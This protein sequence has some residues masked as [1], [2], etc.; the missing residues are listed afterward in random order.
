MGLPLAGIFQNA[1]RV[2]NSF[3]AASRFSMKKQSAMRFDLGQPTWNTG[4]GR[5][6][7]FWVSNTGFARP[8]GQVA[9]FLFEK[10]RG[11]LLFTDCIESVPLIFVHPNSITETGAFGPELAPG[12]FSAR[13]F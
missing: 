12:G 4:G 5:P 2:G 8:L 11:G 13:R 1:G 3:V 9:I 10:T 6:G 7:G